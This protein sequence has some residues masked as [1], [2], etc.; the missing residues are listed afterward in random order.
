MNLEERT[1]VVATPDE[2]RFLIRDA[3]RHEIAV[4]KPKEEV[5]EVLNEKQAADFIGQK[6]GT[7]RQ[8]RTNS[9]GP[10]YHKM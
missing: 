3:V 6:P 8:W 1:I 7:L 2:L 10:A 9:K 5:K 4:I